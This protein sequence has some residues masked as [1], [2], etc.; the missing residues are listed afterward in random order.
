VGAA[1]IG[2][3][4]GTLQ[5]AP[6]EGLLL[7][8]VAGEDSLWLSH[9][10]LSREEMKAGGRPVSNLLSRLDAAGHRLIITVEAGRVSGDVTD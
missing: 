7:P 9:L 10:V 2:Q 3:S 6:A 1:E 5:S 4:L 8:A